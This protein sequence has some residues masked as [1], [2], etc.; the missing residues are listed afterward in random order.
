M[1]AAIADEFVPDARQ[2]AGVLDPVFGVVLYGSVHGLWAVRGSG[3]G[4]AQLTGGSRVVT[5]E[6]DGTL[7][8]IRWPSARAGAGS[9]RRPRWAALH[10]APDVAA[11]RPAAPR[12]RAGL[13]AA[14]GSDREPR[15]GYGRCTRS[16]AIVQWADPPDRTGRRDRPP[17]GLALPA[18]GH[19][20]ALI[21]AIASST[22]SVTVIRSRSPGP[23][24][25][26]RLSES[27]IQSI[28]PR[29]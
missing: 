20:L 17:A 5:P 6:G 7:S 10:V 3:I 14:R 2:P 4:V 27:R 15:D 16:Y 23:I 21:A 11:A 13:L 28:S 9:S 24:R 25:P 26:V 22:S 1:N 29:Q 12:R 18:V 8:T 19:R